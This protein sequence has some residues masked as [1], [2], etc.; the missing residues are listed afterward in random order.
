MMNTNFTKLAESISKLDVWNLPSESHVKVFYSFITN[1]PISLESWRWLAQ[2]PARYRKMCMVKGHLTHYLPISVCEKAVNKDMGLSHKGNGE[3]ARPYISAS[4]PN[5]AANIQNPFETLDKTYVTYAV[6]GPL[7]SQAKRLVDSLVNQAKLQAKGPIKISQTKAKGVLNRFLPNL[8]CQTW[9]ELNVKEQMQILE[10]ILTNQEAMSTFLVEHVAGTIRFWVEYLSANAHTWS[11]MFREDDQLHVSGTPYNYG[12][13]SAFLRLMLEPGTLGEAVHIVS[14]KCIGIDE[15]QAT[16]ASKILDEDLERYFKTAETNATAVIDGPGLFKGLLPIQV[17]RRMADYCK[18][19]RPDISIITFPDQESD[20]WMV[21]TIEDGRI[22]PHKDCSVPLEARLTYFPSSHCIGQDIPQKAGGIAVIHVDKFTQTWQIMQWLFRF[23]GIK[24]WVKILDPTNKLDFESKQ[25]AFFAMRKIDREAIFGAKNLDPKDLLE[26]LTNL[27]KHTM[28]RELDVA[29]QDNSASYPHQIHNVVRTYLR[30]KVLAS[31][32]VDEM[33]TLFIEFQ[34]VFVSR[35]EYDP[36]KQF[37]MQAVMKPSAEVV[38]NLKKRAFALVHKSSLQADEKQLIH[39]KLSKL[40]VPELPEEIQVYVDHRNQIHADLVVNVQRTV[41]IELSCDQEDEQDTETDVQLETQQQNQSQTADKRY[42]THKV[43]S[44]PDHVRADST[45]WMQFKSPKELFD[46]IETDFIQEIGKKVGS[47]ILGFFGKN[48]DEKITD[49]LPPIF[50]L[51]T[52][53]EEG[54]KVPFCFPTLLPLAKHFDPR[55]WLT[56]NFLPL[57]ATIP[58]EVGNKLQRPPLQVLLHVQE[59]NGHI[60][61]LSAGCLSASDAAQWRDKLW[62]PPN[63]QTKVLLYDM[64]HR[65]HVAGDF[66]DEDRL[67]TPDFLKLEVQIKFLNGDGFYT[68]KQT[69]VLSDWIKNGCGVKFARKAFE[70]IFTARGE[71]ELQVTTI[72][73]L[74]RALET[75]MP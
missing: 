1:Q 42:P 28:L 57:I 16:E 41:S 4:Q 61:T 40:K 15:L 6:D 60:N 54:R 20:K 52:V 67:K 7:P 22:T 9:H 43:I 34:P 47:R 19:H 18:I 49:P 30:D 25:K 70:D 63:G 13:Y 50:T 48:V 35:Q 62:T 29:L 45:D 17:V 24:K 8:D 58:V 37:G 51:K 66:V 38:L 21:L 75:E 73:A 36:I 5:E 27:I 39:D 10:T 56:G 55:I 74:F 46:N 72:Y 11:T 14:K 32:T 64:Q 26:N 68:K 12:C 23:R 53:L 31:R 59:D 44:W 2:N 33:I 71:G 65:D 3:Y 69:K